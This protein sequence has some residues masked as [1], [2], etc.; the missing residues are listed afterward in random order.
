MSYFVEPFIF[1]LGRSR[2]ILNYFSKNLKKSMRIFLL[3][4]LQCMYMGTNIKIKIYRLNIFRYT[5]MK[6][7]EQERGRGE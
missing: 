5:Y 2:L 6:K 7:R 4:I 3:S 1:T